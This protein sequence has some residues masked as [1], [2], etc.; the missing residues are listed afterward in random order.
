MRLIAE[1]IEKVTAEAI[2]EATGE[3]MMILDQENGT[4]EG[5]VEMKD[6][7]TAGEVTIQETTIEGE[8][9]LV[10]EMTAM[11]IE[12][13][14]DRSQVTILNQ[15]IIT[16]PGPNHEFLKSETDLMKNLVFQRC[17]SRKIIQGGICM[18]KSL[19]R[20]LVKKIQTN[21]WA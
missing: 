13:D 16:D 15:G 18:L 17:S 21:L 12:E 10:Q 9:H 4:V 14:S 3:G 6:N 19:R 8:V 20:Y 2:G 1:V 5:T 11:T 7:L